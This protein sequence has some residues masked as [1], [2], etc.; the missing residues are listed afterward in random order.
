MQITHYCLI[1]IEVE[2][3]RWV[4]EKYS[5]INFHEMS[6]EGDKEFQQD[7]RTDRLTDMATLTIASRDFANGPKNRNLKYAFNTSKINVLR[8]GE[9]LRT[10]EKWRMNGHNTVVV[11]T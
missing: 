4:F 7:G 3:S 8:K 9:K 6:P 5:N 2:H 11:Y 1:L 10:N